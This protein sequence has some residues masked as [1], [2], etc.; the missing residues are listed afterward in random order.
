MVSSLHLILLV[1]FD[2]TIWL[3]TRQ[4]AMFGQVVEEICA[5]QIVVD[6]SSVSAISNTNDSEMDNDDE[7]VS[8]LG[9]RGMYYLDSFVSLNII[10]RTGSW[11]S[12][13]RAS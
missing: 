13:R 4:D 6:T 10:I 11:S 12:P 9:V 3:I 8:P 2:D 7:F 5:S 1:D